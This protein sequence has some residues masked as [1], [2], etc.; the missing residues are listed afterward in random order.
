MIADMETATGGPPVSAMDVKPV[1]LEGAGVRL[2]PL[3]EAHEQALHAILDP[4]LTQWFPKP[5]RTREDVRAYIAE[6]LA[7][8]RAGTGLPFATTL[9]ADGGLVG[10]TRFANIDRAN[11]RAEIGWTLVA[12]AHQRSAVNT[13]A[14]LLMLTHAFETWGCIR[15]EFKTDSLNFQSRTALTRLGATEEGIFRNHVICADGRLR[16][17]VYFSITN[18]EWPA[19]KQRLIRR[20]AAGGHANA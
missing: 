5:M 13:E 1:T 9:R 15:V 4:A 17:S 12:R 10:V 20:M 3:T 11:R 16:H 7:M 2:E 6:A 18:D 19:I 14:K 8:Q